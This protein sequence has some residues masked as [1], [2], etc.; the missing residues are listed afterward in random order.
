MADDF[1]RLLDKKT[2]V[3]GI[4]CSCCD[5]THSKNR[6][7]RK[8]SRTILTKMVRSILKRDLKNKL[9]EI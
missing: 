2:G 3:G 5:W 7:N 8:W 1:R 6:T 4:H 9:N